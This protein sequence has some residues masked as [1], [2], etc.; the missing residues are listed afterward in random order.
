MT[1]IIDPRHFLA[2]KTLSR[3]AHCAGDRT[4]PECDMSAREAL[5]YLATGESH[6]RT[7]EG[8]PPWWEVLPAINDGLADE[9]RNSLLRPR[10][11]RYA[12]AANP[13]RDR[14]IVRRLVTLAV[15]RFAADACRNLH[16]HA[17]KLRAFGPIGP[18]NATAAT[19]A[20]AAAAAECAGAAAACDRAADAAFYLQPT[21]CP[22]L[23]QASAAAAL[24]AAYS[25][26]ADADRRIEYVTLL[27][28]AIDEELELEPE[29][30]R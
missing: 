24:A 16:E 19:D 6:D 4:S 21:G 25:A 20:C 9:E 12:V 3:G 27:L 30:V 13:A 28:D 1:I 18:H 5:C 2:N 22:Y 17:E 29:V 10:L 26:A 11:W 23:A 14:R 7:P 15:T 8:C